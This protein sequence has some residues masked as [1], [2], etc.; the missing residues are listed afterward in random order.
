MALARARLLSFRYPSDDAT[1]QESCSDCTQSTIPAVQLSLAAGRER[2]LHF[3]Y[4]RNDASGQ[5]FV[6]WLQP[7]HDSCISAVPET[8][9][10][11]QESCCGSSQ[12]MIPA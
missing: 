3:R 1:V 11:A 7:R 6:L 12:G 2:F 5:F 4:P 9:A 8:S 10:S